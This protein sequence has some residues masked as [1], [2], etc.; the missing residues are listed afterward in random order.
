M[1]LLS[2]HQQAEGLEGLLKTL[3]VTHGADYLEA[4]RDLTRAYSVTE[5]RDLLLKTV[6][7]LKSCFRLA[8]EEHVALSRS[9]CKCLT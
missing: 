8:T 6:D 7:V 2:L 4:M 5:D 3:L 1:Q 9:K